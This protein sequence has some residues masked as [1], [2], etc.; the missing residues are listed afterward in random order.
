MQMTGANEIKAML[1]EAGV[2]I[3]D[4]DA[5]RIAAALAAILSDLRKLDELAGEEGEPTPRFVVEG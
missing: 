1:G 4:D 3:G 5:R 2:S